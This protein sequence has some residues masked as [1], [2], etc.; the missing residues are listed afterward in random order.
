MKVPQYTIRNIPPSVDRYLRKRA[1]I[2][3]L[4]LNQTI[5]NELTERAGLVDNDI[6]DSLEW[7]IGKG[8]IGDD[9]V[10]VIEDDD[11]KQ[12]RLLRKEWAESDH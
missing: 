10:M 7:F 9:A 11:K 8:F 1:E 5:V 2:S 3:G 4:S 6:V 12:K